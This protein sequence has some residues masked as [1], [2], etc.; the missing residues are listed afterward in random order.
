MAVGPRSGLSAGGFVRAAVVAALVVA[1]VS[2]YLAV[3]DLNSL[4]SQVVGFLGNLGAFA[5]ATACCVRAARRRSPARAAWVLMAVA[6]GLS[7]LSVASYAVSFVGTEAPAS[8]P[9]L[10]VV[11]MVAYA[12]PLL[13]AMLVFPRAAQGRISVYR[14]ILDAAVIT[15]GFLVISWATVLRDVAAATGPGAAGGWTRLAYPIADVVICAVVLALGMRQ[16]PANRPVWLCFGAGIVTLA[17]TDSVYIALLSR[18]GLGTGQLLGSPLACGWMIAGALIGLA[19]LVPRR[20][21]SRRPRDLAVLI[22][23]VPYGPV[24]GA[25][26]ILFVRFALD[27]VVLLVGE[28]LLLVLV[29]SRQVVMVYENVSIAQHLEEKVAARTVELTAAREDALESSRL[30]SEFLATMSHEIRTPMNGVIGLT[31]LLLST[32]LDHLQHQYTQGVR[33]AGEALLTLINDILDFS[34][35]D[36]GK[37]SLDPSDFDLSLVVEELGALLAPAAFAK[38]LELIAFCRPGVPPVVHGDAGRIRQIVLNLASNA[39]KF[40]AEGEVVLTVESVGEDAGLVRLHFAVSDTGIG[41]AEA[42]RQRVFESFS[43]ADSSTTRQFGGT[44]LGLAI[45]RRLVE[46]MG[47][48]IGV[49]S[50]AGVGSTFWFEIALPVGAPLAGTAQPLD[51]AVL[52]ARRVL[53]VDDNATNRT[54]LKAQLSSWKIR[55]DLVED[56]RTALRQLRLMAGK[57]RP[58][59]AAVL[60]LMMPHVDGLQLARSISTDPVLSGLPMMMLTSSMQVDPVV[61]RSVGI[62]QWLSKPLRSADLHDGLVRL[63]SPQ[64][65]EVVAPQPGAGGAATASSAVRGQ[66]LVV[67]DDPLNQLVA[68]GTLARMGYA[69]RSVANGVEALAAVATTRYSAI[70]MDCHMPVMDG[71]AATGEIRRR[72]VG[73]QRTPVIAMTAGARPQDRRRCLEAGMDDYVSKPIDGAALQAV[74]DRWVHQADEHRGPVPTDR[75]GPTSARAVVEV[76][77]VLDRSRLSDLSE[78]Q[79][80]EGASLLTS[81]VRA[82]IDRSGDRLVAMRRATAT[83]ELDDLGAAVHELKGAAGT[84]GAGRVAALCRELEVC[85][86]QDVPT[87]RDGLLDEL[88]VELADAADQLTEFVSAR[89]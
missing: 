30:K 18:T 23:L 16:S 6:T 28:L 76:P 31:S 82:F 19:T 78:L 8:T 84:I 51:P 1:G 46:A 38:R 67:E 83:G 65:P 89:S 87:L 80:S 85:G 52:V 75:P 86:H 58:Y 13:A 20:W 29:M 57:G 72:E 9:V 71:Y 47:G 64:D 35:L 66:V 3:G 40:T 14:T 62:R 26:L 53:V 17:V 43:Q 22:Q 61:L 70:L 48:E 24:L 25:Y 69:V 56:A 55:P 63:L 4:S 88:E 21:S 42:D 15:T 12:V 34:K 79:T 37:V 50:A 41:I 5:F 44:G 54:I 73:G 36:A 33:T 77:P 59:D 60:D 7:S 74:L 32:R 68:E 39:V 27:D 2:V 45:S 49:T 10:D 81:A 11:G